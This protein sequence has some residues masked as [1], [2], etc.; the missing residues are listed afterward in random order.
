MELGGLSA[1]NDF[2]ELRSEFVAQVEEARSAESEEMLADVLGRIV[3]RA[4]HDLRYQSENGEPEQEIVASV[5]A[6]ASVLSYATARFY[7]EGPESMRKGG[8]YDKKVVSRLQDAALTFSS[9]LERALQATG[10][11]SFSTSVG[12]PWGLSVG[13]DWT[14]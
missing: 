13:L 3:D 8:G 11:V 14:V 9:Y 1:G 2:D 4:D 5:D 12:F 7:F 10:A 6:W